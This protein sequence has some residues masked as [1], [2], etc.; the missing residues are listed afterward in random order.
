MLKVA[1]IK[2]YIIYAEFCTVTPF[3]KFGKFNKYFL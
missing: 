3:E 1:Q 2:V